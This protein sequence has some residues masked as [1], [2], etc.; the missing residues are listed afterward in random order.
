MAN[1]GQEL[2]LAV[3][4]TVAAHDLYRFFHTRDDE[5]R[6]L[7]G[8]SFSVSRGE[9]VALMG[10]SGSGKSTLLACL[11]G[12]DVP[13]GGQVELLG[14]RIARLS[15]AERTARR[16]KHIGILMQSRNLFSDLTVEENVRLPLILSDQSDDGQVSRLLK[17]IRLSN[18][19][20]ALSGELSGGEAARV[21][22]AIA[23]VRNPELVLADEPTAEVD[24]DTEKHLLAILRRHCDTGAAVVVATHSTA[25]AKTASRVIRIADGRIADDSGSR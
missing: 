9:F 15:E 10:P 13:D 5:T 23:L 21:G 3:M 12:L 18:R 14:E 22:L 4:A 24:A 2:Q 1:D 19:S 25:L 17:D 8:I 6:A 7:R 16:L 20:F 11:A